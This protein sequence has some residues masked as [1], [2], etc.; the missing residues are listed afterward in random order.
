MAIKKVS[1]FTELTSLQDNDMFLVERNGEGFFIKAS[2]LKSYFGSEEQDASITFVN[3]KLTINM[4]TDSGI[5]ADESASY[6]RFIS[7]SYSGIFNAL[8]SGT[9]YSLKVDGVEY[10]YTE[11]SSPELESFFRVTKNDS[12]LNIQ[13]YKTSTQSVMLL[14]GSDSSDVISVMYANEE[15][16]EQM[17]AP[18]WLPSSFPHTVEFTIDPV[19]SSENEFVVTVTSDNNIPME[20]NSGTCISNNAGLVDWLSDKMNSNLSLIYD[21]NTYSYT[22]SVDPVEYGFT[23]DIND[24]YIQMIVIGAEP[25]TLYDLQVTMFTKEHSESFGTMEKDDVA[26][27]YNL[28]SHTQLSD[29]PVTFKFVYNESVEPDTPDDELTFTYSE[30]NADILEGQLSTVATG[31]T[32]WIYENATL[33][34]EGLIS[35]INVTFVDSTDTSYEANQFLYDAEINYMTIGNTSGYILYLYNDSVENEGEVAPKDTS[36][37]INGNGTPVTEN[38]PITVTFKKSA[39][40]FTDTSATF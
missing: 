1:E 29:F 10:T 11:E 19:T 15:L 13:A 40:V 14:M 18:T 9:T 32:D 36:I 24:S 21:E 33:S 28:Y 39:N 38:Y 4:P 30:I 2:T 17:M 31:L 25:V 26:V 35:G 22:D 34:E 6:A 27:A 37:I 23:F 5:A 3:N 16:E 7:F 20:N 8:N 12:N